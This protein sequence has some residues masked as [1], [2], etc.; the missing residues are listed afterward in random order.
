MSLPGDAAGI[1][2]ARP[3]SVAEMF[4]R[5]AARYDLLN[6]LMTFGMDEGWRQRAVT[7]ARLPPDGLALDVGTGTGALALAL[8]RA[9]PHAR[10]AGVDFAAPMVARAPARARRA[11]LRTRMAFARAD[12]LRL[13]FGDAT[14]DCVSSA[15]VVR[16]VA[17][18]EQA[19]AE[20]LRVLRPGGRMV[21][22]ELTRTRL[23]VFR[24]L[25]GW[26]FHRWVPLLGALVAGDAAAYSYLPESV[27]AFPGPDQLSALIAGVGFQGVRYE[28]LG[29]GTVALHVG[30]RG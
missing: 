3:S 29:L 2:R 25:F 18:R 27:A 19:F 12:A 15:F 9:A 1:H 30:A 22:L 8:A 14:F 5:I 13:P 11:G 26:Y 28:L 20:Q 17:D 6:T 23:P 21:C 4:G 10:I 24:G 16:N 7:A